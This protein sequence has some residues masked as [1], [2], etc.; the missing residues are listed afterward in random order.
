MKE[1]QKQNTTQEDEK[2]DHGRSGQACESEHEQNTIDG[3]DQD[4]GSSFET[5]SES[6]SHKNQRIHQKKYPRSWSKDAT[7]QTGKPGRDTK[8]TEVETGHEGSIPQ[9]RKMDE[10]GCGMERKRDCANERG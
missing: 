6:D 2:Q 5:V 4:N 8:T 3:H 10:K 1:I 7:V 9:R